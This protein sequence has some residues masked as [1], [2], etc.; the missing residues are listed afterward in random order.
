MA[1]IARGQVTVVIAEKGDPGAAGNWTSYV[2]K[3]S[4]TQPATP[5]G[6]A[7]TPSGWVDAPTAG[8]TWWMSKATVNG[9]TGVAGAWSVPIQVTGANGTN[10]TNGT[11]GANGTNGND[12]QYTAYNFA[13]NTSTTTA[14][15][16]GWAA[17]PSAL[18]SG[19]YL[20]MRTGTVVPPATAPAAWNTAVRISGEKGDK[21]DKGDTGSTGATGATG[22]AGTAGPGIVYRGVHSASVIYYNNSLRR[23]IVKYGTNYYVYK[24]AN[25]VATAWNAANWDSFGAE[26]TSVATELLLAQLAYIENLGVKNLK[27]AT[28][29]QRVEITQ[30]NNALAFYDN[31]QAY[32]VVEIKTTSDGIY[33]GQ[34]SGILVKHPA[35]NISINNA[36]LHNG[37]EGAGVSVPILAWSQPETIA[38]NCILQSYNNSNTNKYKTG[39]YVDVMG[40]QSTAAGADKLTAIFT[41]AGMFMQG[42]ASAFRSNNVLCG[43][44]AAGRVSSSGSLLSSVML[45]LIWRKLFLSL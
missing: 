26:F 21:G 14:P 2:F 38:Q 45:I 9:T 25:G 7:T 15:T 30:A 11:N 32:P 42:G 4:S 20:W 1:V 16:A 31:S 5:T 24:G 13:K 36:I 10:G 37:S 23:D 35:S 33:M 18:T 44:T 8:G 43:V 22:S 12:G 41:T 34:G 3:S 29:G 19:E 39:L 6:T 40:T 17:S 28:A 27:T